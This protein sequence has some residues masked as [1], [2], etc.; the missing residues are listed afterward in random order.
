MLDFAR[1]E[2]RRA[3]DVSPL[4]LRP[5]NN[6][7]IDIPRS[8]KT[9]L[10]FDHEQNK[11]FL[12]VSDRAFG[13]K[14]SRRLATAADVTRQPQRC[15]DFATGLNPVLRYLPK[16]SIVAYLCSRGAVS[17]CR[18]VDFDGVTRRKDS[19]N[20]PES[21]IEFTFDGAVIPFAL[22]LMPHTRA[23]CGSVQYNVPCGSFLESGL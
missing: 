11:H 16:S 5:A 14:M 12:T 8:P 18:G 15:A 20:R 7:G 2:L 22:K 1:S 6:Q 17:A 4:I 3:G 23:V 21:R 9:D 19:Q 13:Q 10:N